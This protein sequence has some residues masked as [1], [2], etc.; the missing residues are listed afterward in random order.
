MNL[1]NALKQGETG[2]LSQLKAV[3][4]AIKALESG[5]KG[6]IPPDHVRTENPV[7]RKRMSAATRA[8]I[9]KKAKER[10]AKIRARRAK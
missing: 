1:L 7:V 10:W 3:R 5:T 9:S 6:S 8:R 2:L 4:Q